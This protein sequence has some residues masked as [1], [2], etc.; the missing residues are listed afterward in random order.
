[1][2]EVLGVVLSTTWL[3]TVKGTKRRRLLLKL[4]RFPSAYNKNVIHIR[5][6]TQVSLTGVH[7]LL[8]FFLCF[9]VGVY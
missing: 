3:V 9:S 4:V 7:C 1:M 5:L 6:Y 2:K 8:L